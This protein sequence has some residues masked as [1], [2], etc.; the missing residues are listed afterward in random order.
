MPLCKD[1]NG[2]CGISRVVAEIPSKVVARATR[3]DAKSDVVTR[4]SH[5]SIGYV[6]PR[7]VPPDGDDNVIPLLDRALGEVTLLTGSGRRSVGDLAQGRRD[8]FA[9]GRDP[10]PAVPSSGRRVEDY[11][12]AAVAQKLTILSNV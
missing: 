7:A 8:Q 6:T 1:T 10:L 11:E 5:E 4:A 12:V 2:F 3:Q 9:V